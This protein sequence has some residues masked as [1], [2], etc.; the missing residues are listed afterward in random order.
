MKAKSESSARKD[1]DFWQ[2]LLVVEDGSNEDT[3]DASI[4]RSPLWRNFK[5]TENLYE[6][7]KIEIA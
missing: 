1:G 2:T 4:S 6:M 7:D 3:R 5:P